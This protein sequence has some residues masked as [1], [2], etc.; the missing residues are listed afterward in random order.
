MIQNKK[1]LVVI[2]HPDDETSCGGTIA[3]LTREQNEVVIAIATN[4]DKG[5]HTV[6]VSPQEISATRK[7]EMSNTAAI[8]GV[9]DVIWLGFDDGTLES[10]KQEVK[11][12]CFRVIRQEK[13]DV[14]LTFDPW[15]RWDVHSDHRTIGFAASEAAY[16]A[17]G[18]W[19]YPEQ[20]SEGLEPHDVEETYL[21][22]SDEPNYWVDVKDTFSIKIE[23][24]DA[25]ESQSARFEE[26]FGER[27]LSFL[28]SSSQN[29]D[30]LYKEAFRKLNQSK[31]EL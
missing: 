31:L 28:K 6:N 13:P 12:M 11:E 8:L 25:H 10:R 16:L 22:H 15:K 5:T 29:E 21:F 24:A 30:D 18:C 27:V 23:A 4:G 2:A 19:Y 17:D 3:K 26:T 1:V 20:L 9:K 7:K 14:V